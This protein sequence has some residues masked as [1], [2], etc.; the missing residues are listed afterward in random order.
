MSV[1]HRDRQPGG[2]RHVHGAGRLVAALLAVGIVVA[3]CGGSVESASVAP[4]EA[5]PT[6]EP[7]TSES[8][9]PTEA[10]AATPKPLPVTLV[11][12][13]RTV[14]P[15]DMASVTVDTQKGADCS[16][17]IAYESGTSEASGLGDKTAKAKANGQVTWRWLVGINTNP[18]RAD[19][20]VDCESGERSGSVS[21]TIIVK[22]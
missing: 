13:T 2:V 12:R 6:P 15:G 17:T 11:S 21:T 1:L 19:V 3:A 9:A 5:P 10:P 8:P 22:R 16:I 7:A 14:R 18:Q 4:T 20:T